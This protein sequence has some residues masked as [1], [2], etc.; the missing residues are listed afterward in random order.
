MSK[1]CKKNVVEKLERKKLS[2]PKNCKK[3]KNKYGKFD[4][5]KIKTFKYNESNWKRMKCKKNGRKKF[6]TLKNVKKSDF[7]FDFSGFFVNFVENF[8]FD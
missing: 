2:I 3:I 1:K 8:R 6:R 4:F 5:L 7:L